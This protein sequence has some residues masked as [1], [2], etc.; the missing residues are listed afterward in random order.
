MTLIHGFR[1]I[2]EQDIPEIR[3]RAQVYEHV[4]TGGRQIGRAHV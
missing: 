4:K 3:T 2:R 1:K